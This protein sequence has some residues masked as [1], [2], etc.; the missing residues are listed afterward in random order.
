MIFDVE[1]LTGPQDI[2][3]FVGNDL[4]REETIDGRENI[5]IVYDF[6]SMASVII[7][8]KTIYENMAFYKA[9]V[10]VV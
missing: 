7:R 3:V 6:V 4:V 1:T 5:V 2:Q 8:P 10:F 9:S